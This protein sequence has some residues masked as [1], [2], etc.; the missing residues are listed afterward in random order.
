MILFVY[1]H[2]YRM[3]RNVGRRLPMYAVLTPQKSAGLRS[4]LRRRVIKLKSPT[5]RLKDEAA[6]VARTFI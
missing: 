1:I 3:C 2:V 6:V 4:W 5:E